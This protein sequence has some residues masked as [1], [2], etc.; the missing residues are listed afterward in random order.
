[1]KILRQFMT[2]WLDHYLAAQAKLYP[3]CPD[4]Y[5]YPLWY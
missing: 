5:L 3:D 2:R 1:M 4:A